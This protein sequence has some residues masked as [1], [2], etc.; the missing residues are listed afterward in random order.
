MK[1]LVLA[2]LV[3]LLPLCAPRTAWAANTSQAQAPLAKEDLTIITR[4][5]TPHLFHVEMAITGDQQEIGLMW[6]TSLAADQGML[7]DFGT[8]K[9]ST[10]W[11]DNTLIPLD[12]VYISQDGTVAAITED[13][14]PRSLAIDSS[15]VPVRATLELAGGIT[16]KLDIRVGDRVKQRIFNNAG[17]N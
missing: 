16:E 17:A 3:S 1:R 9:V 12:M 7:F 11:M 8:S 13:A 6:R 10:M 15:Q 4:D 14:V 5:G 2:L